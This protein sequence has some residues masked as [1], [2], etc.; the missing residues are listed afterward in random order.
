M[1]T[2]EITIYKF[3]EL[4]EK[5]KETARSWW[6]SHGIDYEWW[7][8]TYE[9][10]ENI[11]L[12]I[13]EFDIGRSNKIKGKLSGSVGNCCR[14]IIKHHGKESDTYKLAE[15]YYNR[16]KIGKPFTEEEFIHDLLECYLSILRNELEYLESDENVDENIRINEYEF[17]E[18]GKIY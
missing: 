11:G 2:E 4:S 14:L 7:D 16:K 10:A 1:R 6:R 15:D 13:T 3:D 5:A 9:D 18:D 17:T 8:S 12:T